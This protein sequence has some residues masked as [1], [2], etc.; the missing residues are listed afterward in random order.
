MN[1]NRLYDLAE[2]ENIKIY[3]Y[4][5]DE[6]INGIF[7]NYDT[8]NVIGLNYKN[9]DD[10]KQEKCVLSEELA[11]YYMDAIYNYKNVDKVLY[12]KQEYRAKKWSYYTLIPYEKL[13]SAILKRY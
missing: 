9:F 5:V 10:T 8:L 2:T 13:K 3:N 11:H 1:L 4:R 6:G 12:D 7:L